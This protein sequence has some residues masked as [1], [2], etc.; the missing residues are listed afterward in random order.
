MAFMKRVSIF[1]LYVCRKAEKLITNRVSYKHVIF[2]PENLNLLY[3]KI[4][5]KISFINYDLY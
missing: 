5:T 1:M 2:M 4:A 3:V